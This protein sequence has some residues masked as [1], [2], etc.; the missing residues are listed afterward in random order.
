[1]ELHD[2]GILHRLADQ[3]LEAGLGDIGDVIASGGTS[4]RLRGGEAGQI[5]GTGACEVRIRHA[6][7]F[8]G[9]CQFPQLEVERW[10]YGT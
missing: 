2:D 5:Y 1:M 8:C 6:S 9:R 3:R 7:N 10:G 4:S